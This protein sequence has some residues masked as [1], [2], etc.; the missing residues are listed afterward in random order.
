[1]IRRRIP[2]AAALVLAACAPA[3][4]RGSYD[5]PTGNNRSYGRETAF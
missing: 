2:V 1:M 5:Y 4:T 3:A